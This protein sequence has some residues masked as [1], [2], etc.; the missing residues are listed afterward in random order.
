MH[1]RSLANNYRVRGLALN[2]LSLPSPIDISGIENNSTSLR[3]SEPEYYAVN[4]CPDELQREGY[5]SFMASRCEGDRTLQQHRIECASPRL[6]LTTS[7]RF[8]DG[9]CRPDQ[10][11]VEFPRRNG[12]TV[13]TCNPKQRFGQNHL[14]MDYA[15]ETYDGS[16]LRGICAWQPPGMPGGLSVLVGKQ[17]DHESPF[18]ADMIGILPLHDDSPLLNPVS[19]HHCSRLSRINPPLINARTNKN[20]ILVSVP[21]REDA[22]VL[23]FAVF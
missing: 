4:Q 15:I 16:N 9:S 22:P 20:L 21:N 6:G 3:R 10:F 5:S 1:K 8:V 14:T 7:S 11:C 12:Q 19:C 23:Q 18:N 17:D 13:A 2:C